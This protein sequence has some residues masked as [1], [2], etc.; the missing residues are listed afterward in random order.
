VAVHE[1]LG[2]APERYRQVLHRRFI[3][4]MTSEEIG[5][6]LGIPAAT[7]RSRLYLARKWLRTH[8]PK[9]I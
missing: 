8:Q 6:E 1:L 7:V 9:Y 4:G 3:L 2:S 5:R